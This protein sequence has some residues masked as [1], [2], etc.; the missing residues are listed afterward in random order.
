[1]IRLRAREE[2]QHRLPHRR[3]LARLEQDA[4]DDAVRWRLRGV[5]PLFDLEQGDP[6]L[7]LPYRVLGL[8]K[9]LDRGSLQKLG[10]T[11]LLYFQICTGGIECSHGAIYRL[12][13]AQVLA[14]QALRPFVFD[15]AE[16]KLPLRAGNTCS[17]GGYLFFPRSSRQLIEA[18][19]AL[20][21]QGLRLVEPG[22]Y[23]RRIL[24]QEERA[25]PDFLPPGHAFLH[26]RLGSVCDKLDTIR[27]QLTDHAR[28]AIP[29]VASGQDRSKQQDGDQQDGDSHK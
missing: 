9:L 25:S 14:M 17:C 3:T 24:C 23:A 1:S 16:F 19:A 5:A 22:R 28:R 15:P 13:R 7:E 10:E 20:R 12:L 2:D 8:S 26:D 27:L 11:C 18:R 6:C 4:V 29:G 21:Q